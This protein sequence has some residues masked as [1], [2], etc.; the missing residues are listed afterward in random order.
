[1]HSAF[2][3]LIVANI[4]GLE[5]LGIWL[6]KDPTGKSEKTPY[7]L[8]DVELVSSLPKLKRLSLSPCCLTNAKIAK[9]LNECVSLTHII[10]R[11][12]QKGLTSVAFTS[13]P[14]RAQLRTIE[15]KTEPCFF[16]KYALT[17]IKQ[18]CS[19]TLSRLLLADNTNILSEDVIDLMTCCPRIC[20]L[21][22]KGTS[23]DGTVLEKAL[24]M[25]YRDLYVD[26]RGSKVS[27][28]EFLP[29]KVDYLNR[30][31]FKSRKLST[32]EFRMRNLKFCFNISDDDIYIAASFVTP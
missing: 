24:T 28:A 19:S 23:C 26:C 7:T 1:M 12:K 30:C 5:A 4:P 10:L 31:L 29:G 21:D 22:L 2:I 15:I 27:L 9:I 11:G 13:L 18:Q 8:L 16:N 20:H 14:I 3:T 25:L 32:F 6:E 17:S